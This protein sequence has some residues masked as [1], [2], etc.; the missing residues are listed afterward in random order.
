MLLSDLSTL[1]VSPWVTR[2]HCLSQGLTV[3][4]SFLTV[5]K[6]LI[7]F[8]PKTHNF[9]RKQT[10]QYNPLSK[11]IA[12]LSS[13]YKK[14]II[15]WSLIFDSETSSR[16]SPGN[17]CPVN[18]QKLYEKHPFFSGLVFVIFWKFLRTAFKNAYVG[19]SIKEAHYS[20]KKFC[21]INFYNFLIIFFFR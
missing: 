9:L 18:Y 1:T 13:T 12:A 11:N 3:G 16:S 5:L 8:S 10:R 20:N 14:T 15:L 21:N 19:V 4:S 6:I 2:F 17:N 7:G